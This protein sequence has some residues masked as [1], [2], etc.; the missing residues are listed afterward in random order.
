M[1]GFP[2]P[3]VKWQKDGRVLR[4]SSGILSNIEPDGTI[5]LEIKNAAEADAGKYKLCLS[6]DKGETAQEVQVQVG[7]PLLKPSFSQGLVDTNVVEGFPLELQVRK[8]FSKK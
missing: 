1:D 7:P 2:I 8:T 5:S 4:P 6:N 3:E